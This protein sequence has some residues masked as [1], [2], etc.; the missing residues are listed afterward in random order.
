[1]ILSP[2]SA[3]IAEAN[4][5]ARFLH[6]KQA[7]GQTGGSGKGGGT[8]GDCKQVSTPLTALARIDEKPPVTY[9]G[10]VTT[11][12]SPT[13]WFYVPYPL[14]ANL[15]ANFVLQDAAG[16]T[17]Y[18]VASADFA[19]AQPDE[20][21]GLVGLAL[22][23][24]EIDQDYHWYFMVNC[25][26]SDPEVPIYVDG[27]IRRIQLAPDLESQLATLSPQAQAALYSQHQLWYDA[28]AILA[29]LRRARPADTALKADWDKLLQAMNITDIPRA[30][31][32]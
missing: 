23:N 24:L 14:S 20:I 29:N 32:P 17:I 15:T 4:S 19:A 18:Q 31:I 3:S 30:D 11:A 21:N 9:V 25:D 12:A 28:L 26:A 16:K 8:Y 7:P 13:L 10:G 27:G 1:M 6:P 22:P 5:A 2:F